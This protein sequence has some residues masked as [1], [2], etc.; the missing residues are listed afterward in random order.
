MLGRIHRT[1]Q[2][3]LPKFTLLSADIPAEKRPNAV[4]LK[5]MASLNA[6]T[7]AARKSGI[8]LDSIP[9][10]LNDYGDQVVADIIS[11]DPKL[12][13]QLANPLKGSEDEL[14]TENAI[15]RVTGRIPLLSLAEQEAFYNKLEREYKEL[16][17][18]QEAM[19]ESILEANSLNLDAR[20]IAR[21]DVVPPDPNSNSPF[22]S[23]VYLEVVDAKNPKKP[24]TTLEVAN[25]LRDSLGLEPIDEVNDYEFTK[26]VKEARSNTVEQITSLRK[27]V[28]EYRSEGMVKL[29]QSAAEKLSEKLDKQLSHVQTILQD[30]PVGERV[31]IVSAK[32][33]IFYGVVGEVWEA[34]SDSGNPV[35]PANWRMRILLADQARELTVPL[36]KVNT[37]KDTAI[38]V[39]LQ[40]QDLFTKEDV[41]DLFDLRQTNQRH[42]RQIFT[43]NILRAYEAFDG[44]L[45]NFTDNQGQIRQGILTPQGFD[46]EK[47]LESRPVR[48]PT[49]SDVMKFITEFTQG[50]GSVKSLDEVLTITF[51]KR[52]DEFVLQTPKAKDAGGKFYLDREILNAAGSDF[53]S[54]GERMECVVPKERIDAVLDVIIDKQGIPLAAFGQKNK[55]REMLGIELPGLKAVPEISRTAA[56]ALRET[57]IAPTPDSEPSVHRPENKTSVGDA[58]SIGQPVQVQTENSSSYQVHLENNETQ[59]RDRGVESSPELEI[60]KTDSLSTPLV[61]KTVQAQAPQPQDS[62]IPLE[63]SQYSSDSLD[64]WLKVASALGRS[65]AYISRIEDVAVESRNGKPLSQKAQTAQE[66]DFATYE[67]ILGSMKEWGRVSMALDKSP[68]YVHR[69]EFV[70]KEFEAGKVVSEKALTAQQHDFD[71]YQ[72]TKDRLSS[73]QQIA[74]EL[75]KPDKYKQR[76]KEI[77][78]NLDAV[79]PVPVTDKAR[80]V[81]EQDFL[82]HHFLNKTNQ[83]SPEK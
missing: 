45:V 75:G 55:A 12:N 62:S 20:T 65:N 7:T 78:D 82:S 4:L 34:N 30:Y 2:V 63:E 58:V 74:G 19:G 22:T 81:M 31:R 51:E 27:E 9:D 41:Y 33:N 36:S 77:A 5:K 6:N 61:L 67:A 32:Q 16:V 70:T 26:I 18:R 72:K 54:I 28:E 43:G 21:M 29:S 14:S 42:E 25:V 37:S 66:N 13:R 15:A 3:I 49:A 11:N 46:I 10:F 68:A 76:I 79:E 39:T 1:G 53:Y 35:A 64:K 47:N 38:D 57:S 24:L 48:M 80:K 52:S 40:A 59:V 83:S 60:A 17:E 69:I 44:K 8:S 23:A 73:W 56:P 50:T 71:V